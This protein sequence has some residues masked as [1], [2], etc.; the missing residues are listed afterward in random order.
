MD[1][2]VAYAISNMEEWKIKHL[3]VLEGDTYSALVEE[4]DLSQF[5]SSMKLSEV[6]NDA[7]P[8]PSV[9]EKAHIFEAYRLAA[10]YRLSA[11]PVVSGENHYRGLITQESL[12]LAMG[13]LIPF[14]GELS[15]LVV[16]IPRRDLNLSALVHLVESNNA[17]VL[18]YTTQMLGNGE[19]LLAFLIIDLADPSPVMMSLERFNYK[20]VYHSA[21]YGMRDLVSANRWEE[22]MRYM[23]I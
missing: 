6:I 20:L 15:L 19:N 7:L 1:D 16:E 23:N 17:H 5:S 8:S 13:E 12:F 9:S 4:T 22:L 14:E 18:C 21:K 2:T 11:L 10:Q 3:P